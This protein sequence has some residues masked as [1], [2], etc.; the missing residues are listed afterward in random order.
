MRKLMNL[1]TIGDI[2]V[3]SEDR[4]CYPYKIALGL[5]YSHLT[6][7]RLWDIVNVRLVIKPFDF[8]NVD[9]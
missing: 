8:Y 1:Q 4:T 7:V 5:N 6:V 9:S 2:F 3:P